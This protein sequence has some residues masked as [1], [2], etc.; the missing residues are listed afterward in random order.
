MT[1]EDYEIHIECLDAEIAV[2][3]ELRSRIG[4]WMHAHVNREADM[5]TYPLPIA[6]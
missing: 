1:P 4:L 5:D 3:N 6:G 2:M